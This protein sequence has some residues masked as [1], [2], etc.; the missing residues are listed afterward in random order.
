MRRIVL[1][2][3]IVALAALNAT[4]G[5]VLYSSRSDWEAA[6]GTIHN[7]GFEGL[8]ADGG[9]ADY[10]SAGLDLDG[11]H[12]QSYGDQN[13]L[14][15]VDD[16]YVNDS[17]VYPCYGGG[18]GALLHGAPFGYGSALNPAGIQA[19]FSNTSA[20]GTDIWTILPDQV[21]GD[22]VR[23]IVTVGGVDYTY[24]IE[25]QPGGPPN[26]AFVGFISDD[27]QLITAVKFEALGNDALGPYLDLDNFA[28]AVPEPG[29]LLLLGSGLIAVGVLA[30]RRRSN[31]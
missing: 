29:S 5:P 21:L 26:R 14:L 19:S 3:L 2:S 30:R 1:L 11:V 27:D 15:V 4:A 24:T 8:A 6:A 13:Y 28:V 10:T 7:I 18:T 31:P 20:V 16:T 23:V 25:T 17:C 12:F 9:L 22:E